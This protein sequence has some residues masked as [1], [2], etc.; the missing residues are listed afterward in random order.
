MASLNFSWPV[1]TMRGKACA[2][3]EVYTKTNKQTGK[4]YAVKLC[5][6]VDGSKASAAQKTHRTK[7]AALC[8]AAAAWIEAEKV[9]EGGDGSVAYN[10]ALAAFRSQ[11]KYGSLRGFIISKYATYDAA[12]QKVTITVGGSTST[13]SG[14]SGGSTP[15]GGSSTSGDL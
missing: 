15:G 6:P 3:D 12:T 9:K 14:G 2:H 5:N 4:S 10:K 1:T 11:H 7:F 13:V 8:S